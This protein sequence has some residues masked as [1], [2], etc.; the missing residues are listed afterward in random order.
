MANEVNSIWHQSINITIQCQLVVQIN[1]DPHPLIIHS[2][3]TCLEARNNECRRYLTNCQ[4]STGRP[5]AS[6]GF[7]KAGR[8]LA[9]GG[10]GSCALRGQVAVGDR[11]EP[12]ITATQDG[13]RTMDITLKPGKYATHQIIYTSSSFQRGDP[14]LIHSPERGLRER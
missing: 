9:D 4:K 10:K 5:S 7:W 13:H 3:M 1:T 14:R 6:L 11:L 12:L 2:M 8:V